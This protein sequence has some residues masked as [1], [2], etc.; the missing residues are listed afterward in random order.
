MK[1]TPCVSFDVF[2]TCLVR[3]VIAPSEV[4]RLLG[5][6]IAILLSE[7]DVDGFAN[8]FIAWRLE[9]GNRAIQRS[10]HEEVRLEEVWTALRPMLPP[11]LP[12][13]WDGAAAELELESSLLGAVPEIQ[14]RINECRARGQR[15]FFI[16][17]TPLPGEFVRRNLAA[18]GLWQ[19]GD[20]LYVSSDLRLT[21]CI[22]RL[23]KHVLETEKIT[24]DKLLHIGD[25]RA[26]DYDVPR[27]L[28]I[29][30]ELYSGTQ[31][32]GFELFVLKNRPPGDGAWSEAAGKLRWHR[33]NEKA[34]HSVAAARV[35]VNE[36]L[37]PLLCLWTG[38]VLQQAKRDGVQRLFFVARDTRLL[39]SVASRIVKRRGLALDCRYLQTSRQAVFLP[40]VEGCTPE[41]MPWL[42]TIAAPTLP[43][44]L[45][46]LDLAYAEVKSLWLARQPLWNDQQFLSTKSE[47]QEFWE[48]LQTPEIRQKVAANIQRRRQGASEYFSRIGFFDQ[49]PSALVDVG[50]QL[51]TQMELNRLGQLL[52]KDRS[53]QGYYLGLRQG[54]YG[55]GE[56]GAARALCCQ[57]PHDQIRSAYN[58]CETNRIC[59]IEHLVGTADHPSVTGYGD[60]GTVEYNAGPAG[61]APALFH[62]LETALHEYVDSYADDL[63]GLAGTD[64]ATGELLSRLLHSFF[65]EPSTDCLNALQQFSVYDDQNNLESRKLI[66]PYQWPEIMRA[67]LPAQLARHWTEPPWRIWPEAS[68]K[69]TS[70]A[71]RLAIR[72]MRMAKQP[73]LVSRLG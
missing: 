54:R 64:A 62:D 69:M 63:E 38:W 59:L 13:G 53:L 16:S 24:A 7:S 25:N 5:R 56:A 12:A 20:G 49:C 68:W 22:G 14:N 30:A 40:S 27:S 28:G 2:D 48:F 67:C 43:A 33:L 52:G 57:Q 71:K 34:N 17:D 23:F 21:K 29:N 35:L 50:W 36:F 1:Q 32:Q 58:F 45:G 70:P 26:A 18:H 51:T 46:K 10:S 31:L 39:W 19:T 9:A 66:E 72:C 73:G 4:F 8:D 42:G 61:T 15:I 44:V 41:Q 6:Q 3:K 11:K 65:T 55:A 37:G 47:W 60:N